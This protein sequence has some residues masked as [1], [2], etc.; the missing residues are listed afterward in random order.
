MSA[1]GAILSAAE[2]TL[3]AISNSAN[4]PNHSNREKPPWFG[5][6]SKS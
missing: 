3:S 1:V 5:A 6:A 4:K 2:V